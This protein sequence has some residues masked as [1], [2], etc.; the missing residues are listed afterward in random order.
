MT[1]PTAVRMFVFP[2][3]ASALALTLAFTACGTEISSPTGVD[4]D[5]SFARV[6]IAP[7]IV[8]I[9]NLALEA[10]GSD[11]RVEYVEY[12]TDL[13]SGQMGTTIFANNRGNKRLSRDF[14]PNDPRRGGIDGDPN[15]IDFLVDTGDGATS[16][17][18]S[19]LETTGAILRSTATWDG[20]TCSEM[21]TNFFPAPPFYDLGLVQS[22]LG[23]G[24]GDVFTDIMHAGWM[25]G[26]FFDLVAENGSS[27]ILG[28]TFTL[29]FVSGDLD[30]DGASDLALRE[31]Y[32]NDAFL[33]A[34]DGVSRID[35]ETVALHEAGHGLSQ[36][37]FGK[38]FRTNSN[39]AFHF[40]PRAVMNASYSGV[41]RSLTGTDE[42]GHCTSWANWPQN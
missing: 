18:L 30:E 27:F 1:P 40:S 13:S 39:G 14:I 3:R 34:D 31:I 9:A 26:A 33:W 6:S 21:G 4:V 15:T 5:P 38:I 24:G 11:Y 16:S 23:F 22:I 41:Q 2:R 28:A 10:E 20:A 17:G 35:V 7:T 29:T 42:G 12:Q 32:Y 36:G 25:P 37:H 19:A 8:D